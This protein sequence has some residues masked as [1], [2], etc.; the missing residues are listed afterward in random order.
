MSATPPIE[1]GRVPPH[2][3]DAEAAVL[4]AVMLEPERLDSVA[5]LRPEHFYSDANGRI[6]GAAQALAKVGTPIDIVSVASWLRDRERFAQVGG[7]SYLAQISDATPAVAHVEFH[8]LVVREKWRVRQ[9]IATCQR[10]AAEGYGDFG[11]V[12]AFIAKADDEVHSIAK[13]HSAIIAD[14]PTVD[15]PLRG[16]THLAKV[17]LMGRDRILEIASIPASYVWQDIVVAST[18]AVISGGVGAGKTTLLFLCLAA[19]MNTGEPVSVL[20]RVMTPAPAG[21]LVVLIEGEHGEGS[22]ARK[23]VESCALLRIDDAALDRIIIVARKSVLIGSPEWLDVKRLVAAGLVSDIALDTIARV[24][25]GDANDEA[26]QVAIFARVAEVIEAAPTEKDK[27][28]VWINAH[29]RKGGSGGLDSVSGSAQRTGQA[30]TVLMLSAERED[31]RVTSTTVIFD[32]LREP[33]D[34]Y[35]KPVTFRIMGAGAERQLVT[36]APEAT[37]D[38]DRP[39]GEQILSQLPIGAKKTRNA[40]ATALGKNPTSLDTDI[41][42][43]LSTGQIQKTT[44]SV[45]KRPH[46]GFARRNDAP[47]SNERAA[48]GPSNE[49]AAN[50]QQTQQT[51]AG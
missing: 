4:S 39:L 21:K 46:P 48:N 23:L 3:L 42:N 7:A 38:D 13:D 28:T 35:P 15:D 50:D 40:L 26:Q 41:G 30:D 25:P 49:R 18:I 51:A 29:N 37:A 20:G 43:L 2:D 34:D 19:R 16:L 22:A 6:F 10:V 27:P 32:K 36:D 14:G 45:N 11:E 5:F 44:V 33:P 12:D 1:A 31:G 17:A 24:A 47:R 8:A 9:L